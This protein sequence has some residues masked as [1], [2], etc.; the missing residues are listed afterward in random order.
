MS[1]FLHLEQVW[2]AKFEKKFPS[3]VPSIT[4]MSPSLMPKC[5]AKQKTPT[6][7]LYAY[8]NAKY[9]NFP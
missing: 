8:C 9:T 6:I 5:T 3:I 4:H 7:E 2:I 1:D